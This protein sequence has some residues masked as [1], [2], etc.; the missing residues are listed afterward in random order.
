MRPI[1][2]INLTDDTLI[3][4]KFIGQFTGTSPRTWQARR[5][6]GD[7]PPY[8]R[9]SARCIRYRWGDVRRWMA[10]KLAT[11][12]SQRLSDSGNAA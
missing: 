9:L 4:D 3:D 1:E 11:S 8:V 2:S 6:R 5:V 10:G 7:G 12:T